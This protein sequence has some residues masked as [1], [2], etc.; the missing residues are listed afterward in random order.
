MQMK[1]TNDTEAKAI[2]DHALILSHEPIHITNGDEVVITSPPE[3]VGTVG[4]VRGS[5]CRGCVW[6]D[7]GYP[8]RGYHISARVSD[9]QPFDRYIKDAESTK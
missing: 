6:L 2:V 8:R 7:I 4:V 9:V 1:P 5:A 3:L